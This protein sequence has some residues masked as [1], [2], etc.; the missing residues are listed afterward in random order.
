[1]QH[2]SRQNKMIVELIFC[3]PFAGW[4]FRCSFHGVKDSLA[5]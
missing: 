3:E 4:H 1:M 5:E 2:F